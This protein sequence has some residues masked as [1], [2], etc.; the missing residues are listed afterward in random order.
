MQT[1]YSEQ[2]LGNGFLLKKVSDV[3]KFFY[4]QGE[5]YRGNVL[6]LPLKVTRPG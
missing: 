3:K 6:L 2:L 1:G 4:P 5:V